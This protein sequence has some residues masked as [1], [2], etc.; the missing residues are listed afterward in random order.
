[1]FLGA[2]PL[3]DN[4][5]RCV[6]KRLLNIELHIHVYIYIYIQKCS[7]KPVCSASNLLPRAP[8]P[9]LL[10]P[11]LQVTA[12]I[13]LG[14]LD[15][16]LLQ[17]CWNPPIHHVSWIP[18][19]TKQGRAIYTSPESTERLGGIPKMMVALKW[20]ADTEKVGLLLK[21]V[22]FGYIYIYISILRFLGCFF[23]ASLWVPQKI[24][25]SQSAKLLYLSKGTVP[26][27]AWN[28]FYANFWE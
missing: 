1:M 11:L 8:T 6:S 2:Q 7:L 19:D 20:W 9:T 28:S 25:A 24:E 12:F 3:S 21:Y 23:P 22:F 15:D 13:D 5:M 17:G 27:S 26:K 18:E 10:P 14:R 16:L 4:N